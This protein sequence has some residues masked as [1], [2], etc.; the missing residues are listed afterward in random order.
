MV[1]QA[2]SPLRRP[3][4]RGPTAPQGQLLKGETLNPQSDSQNRKIKYAL[5]LRSFPNNNLTPS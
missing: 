4:Y 2:I 5:Y 1:G 3:Q